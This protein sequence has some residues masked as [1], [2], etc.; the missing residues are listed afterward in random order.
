MT[1]RNEPLYFSYA[2]EQDDGKETT[3]CMNERRTIG[4]AKALPICMS[5]V[6]LYIYLHWK[7]EIATFRFL[8]NIYTKILIGVHKFQS[9][10]ELFSKNVKL[11][12]LCKRHAHFCKNT[13][14]ILWHFK[15][16]AVI[17]IWQMKKS[18][19]SL[20]S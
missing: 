4:V 1:W 3:F 17:Y 2:L 5:I 16:L 8:C 7:N 19:M 11:A 13:I 15:L 12:H 20:E 6:Y 10:F 14:Q 18:H 9:F